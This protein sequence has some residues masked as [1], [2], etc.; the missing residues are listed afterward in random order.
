MDLLNFVMFLAGSEQK[1]GPD[2]NFPE[3]SDSTLTPYA[4]PKLVV[5]AVARWKPDPRCSNLR[6][7]RAISDGVIFQVV[8]MSRWG[9]LLVDLIETSW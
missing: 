5:G 1:Q 4:C 8:L 9:A 7:V 3:T 2:P 6:L